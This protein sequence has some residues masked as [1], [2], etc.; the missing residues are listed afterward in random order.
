MIGGSPTVL[1]APIAP[2]SPEYL[3]RPQSQLMFGPLAFAILVG[4][5]LALATL[6]PGYSHIEQ[7]VSEI[8]QV[9]SPTRLPLALLLLSVAA[10]TL[11]FAQALHRTA[12]HSNNSRVP[13]VLVGAMAASV[14]GVA[15]FAHPHPLHNVFGLSELVGYQAP[16]LFALRWRKDPHA[17]HVIAWSW[18]LYLVIVL[19]IAANL[20][21]PLGMEDLWAY[22]QPRIGLAQRLLF[23]AWF[24]WCAVLGWSLRAPPWQSPT[25][26][27]RAA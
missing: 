11:V 24:G 13:A 15:V 17:E 6:I 1:P 4:G 14:M 25:L 20:S 18:A 26:R 19:A 8:G 21:A 23:A 12:V 16:L 7:T 10:C 5:V 27:D 22:V 9:G 3:V 2:T